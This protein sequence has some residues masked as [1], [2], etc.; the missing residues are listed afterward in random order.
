M[1]C[2]GSS[3]VSDHKERLMRRNTILPRAIVFYLSS[4]AIVCLV[5]GTAEASTSPAWKVKGGGV[6]GLSPAVQVKTVE[7]S[8]VIHS[9]VS[10]IKVEIT[11]T[12]ASLEKTTLQPEGLVSGESKVKLTG[13]TT[14]LNGIK[15]LSCEPRVGAENGVIVS[16]ELK[17][18]LALSENRWIV[19]VV[20]KTGETL[21]TITTSEECLAGKE[22]AVLG[23]FTLKDLELEK[24]EEGHLF[25]EGPSTELW[26]ISKT[27]EHKATVSGSAIFSLTGA[28]TGLAWGAEPYNSGA[29]WLVKSTQVT[30]L[31]PTVGAEIDQTIKFLGK[32]IGTSFSVVCTGAALS[33]FKLQAEG[34]TEGSSINFSGCV[35]EFGGKIAPGC[36]PVGGTLATKGLKGLLTLHAGAGVLR[37]SPK[38]GE[39]IFSYEPGVECSLGLKIV[40]I[41]TIVLKDSV[42]SSEQTTHLFSEG[43]LTEIWWQSKTAEH[44]VALDGSLKT[45]LTGAHSGLSWSGNPG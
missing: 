35:A 43:P 28:H 44:K 34:K 26:L 7:S 2:P 15:Q 13:C 25:V 19:Q 27:E 37:L 29:F 5:P 22:I 10:S 6:S 18:S 39:T 17:T 40:L 31:A 30:S 24:E 41:G 33:G 9:E 3:Y 12:G 32:L 38:E 1:Y 20:P 8:F 23:K 4:L 42:L 14:K 21:G 11:C 36:G 16:N 45:F